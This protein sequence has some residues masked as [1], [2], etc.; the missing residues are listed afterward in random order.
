MATRKT[1]AVLG[2]TGMVG[3][4]AAHAFLQADFA[5]VAL[6]GR[7][8]AK[9]E[10]TKA[11]MP[12][13][14]RVECAL[15]GLSDRAPVHP[16]RTSQAKLSTLDPSFGARMVVITAS[17]AD[18]A[19]AAKAYADVS[20]ALG[21]APTA[22]VSSFSAVGSLATS[23]TGTPYAVLQ[24][25][26]EAD[27]KLTYHAAGAFLPHLKPDPAAS[28]TIV[29]GALSHDVLFPQYWPVSMKNSMS[30][31][32]GGLLT[33]DGRWR[34]AR[35]VLPVPSRRAPF[36]GPTR[37]S[38]ASPASARTTRCASTVRASCARA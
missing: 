4:G 13:C 35:A 30:V 15:A 8:L 11:R 25:G 6:V 38:S 20:A 7:D 3:S 28:Y 14:A 21:G 27:F 37:S 9:L 2:A 12:Q 16:C 36:A 34:G 32:C 10:A 22:V 24:E 17:F 5:A 33:D 26:V 18:A 1:A 19:G 31:P 23:P 29:T